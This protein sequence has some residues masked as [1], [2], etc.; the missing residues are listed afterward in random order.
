MA[1]GG[2]GYPDF[3]GTGQLIALDYMDAVLADY[4]T[5]NTPMSP[6]IQG[7]IVCKDG[8]DATVRTARW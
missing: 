6:A 5:A 8:N 3:C 4:I 1:T 2:Y 7:R